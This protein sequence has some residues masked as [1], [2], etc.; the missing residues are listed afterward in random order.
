M[1]S[2]KRIVAANWKMNL[3]VGESELLATE[4]RSVLT[5]MPRHCEVV[6]APSFPALERLVKAVAGLDSVQIAAQDCAPAIRGAHTG[7]VSSLVLSELGVQKV[8]IGHSERR[9]NNKEDHLTLK[10][11][12]DVA[13]ETGLDIIFC[14]GETTQQRKEGIHMQIIEHQLKDS[15]LHLT[16]TQLASVAIAYEPVWAIG[17]GLTPTSEQIEEM[18]GFLRAL[19]NRTSAKVGPTLSLLYGGSCN[20]SNAASI[21]ALENVDGGLIGGASLKADEFMRI[22]NS[23]P[24]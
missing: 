1:S 20:A 3:T 9:I 6:L 7:E 10:K 5:T 22:L 12:V 18:H 23:L 21:F 4:M 8:I 19:L 16:D 17:T 13:L 14:C 15:L 24:Q 11:K 2:R